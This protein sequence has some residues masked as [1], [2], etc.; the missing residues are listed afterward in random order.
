VAQADIRPEVY[1]VVAWPAPSTRNMGLNQH[2]KN[3]AQSA[4]KKKLF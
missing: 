3:G 2:I 1:Q 4:M